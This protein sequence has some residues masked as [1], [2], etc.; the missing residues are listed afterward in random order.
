M[1]ST[2][3][4]ERISDDEARLHGELAEQLRA[5]MSARKLDAPARFLH[6]KANL[7]LEAQV[8]VAASIPEPLRVG[9]F[10]APSSSY[11]AYVRFS[12]GSALAQHDK[13]G[14]VRGV[15]LK[16]VGVP[17][18]KLIPG[19]EDARTQDF[20][21]IRTPAIPM[22]STKEFIAL[23]R[24]ARSPALLLPRLIGSIGFA[25]TFAVLP[26]LA[27]GLGAPMLPLAATRYFTVLPMAWGP[28]AAKLSLDPHERHEG[29]LPKRSSAT[30]LGDELAARLKSGP[31][32]YD[33]RVQLFEDEARTPIEDPTVEWPEPVAPFHTVATVTLAQQDAQSPRGRRLDADRSSLD[34]KGHPRHRRAED[35]RQ[36]P[37]SNAG[38]VAGVAVPSG[39]ACVRH[40]ATSCSAMTSAPV[41]TMRAATTSA[42][43]GGSVAATASNV[44]PSADSSEKPPVVCA[45]DRSAVKSAP[46]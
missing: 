3:W 40:S 29:P 39:A 46:R 22:R 36:R 14:D 45:C 20:L 38:S 1:P 13:K 15:A 12:N 32:S 2:D 41:S 16:I 19:M 43:A 30:A 11:R 21:F 9:I 42:R 8:T 24:A 25:R 31:V 23:V 34:K 27:K 44:A 26:K 7:G 10:A 33:L 5:Q 17:G 18:K 35:D 6:A 28:Y 37:R 4:K